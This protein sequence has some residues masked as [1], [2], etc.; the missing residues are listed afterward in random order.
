MD[1][2]YT[3]FYSRG[4][5]KEAITQRQKQR[6][7]MAEEKVVTAATTANTEE[8]SIDD[9]G[10]VYDLSHDYK[11]VHKNVVIY[12]LLAAMFNI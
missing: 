1:I 11:I 5:F 9:K 6:E 7:K 2:L 10:E 8:Q 12:L 3:V 4:S